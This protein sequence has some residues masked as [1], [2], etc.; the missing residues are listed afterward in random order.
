LTG[1]NTEDDEGSSSEN[2]IEADSLPGQAIQAGKVNGGID[3]RHTNVNSRSTT[4]INVPAVGVVLGVVLT[5]VVLFVVWRFAVSDD[6]NEIPSAIPPPAS[7]TGP[8]ITRPDKPGQCIEE[9]LDKE[10]AVFQPSRYQMPVGAKVNAFTG[11]SD[12]PIA[13]ILVRD[14]QT[15]GAIKL[16]YQP[17]GTGLQVLEVVDA[18]CA[19]VQYSP[20]KRVAKDD[21]R[22]TFQIG[23]QGY[24]VAIVILTALHLEIT[25]QPA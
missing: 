7:T 19:A 6:S 17:F 24:E 23:G 25:F 8:A 16:F 10:P 5:L 14:R 3:A 12:S 21:Y 9:H 18:S 20:P 15:V 2:R 22:T 11:G 1:G 13:G 4:N